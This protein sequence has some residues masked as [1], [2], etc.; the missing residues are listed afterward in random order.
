MQKRDTLSFILSEQRD[1]NVQ[2][3][4]DAYAKYLNEVKDIF[5]VSAYKLATSDWYFDPN[6]HKCPH[7][8]WL[9][10]ITISEPSEGKRHEIRKTSIKIE[11]IGAYQ[12]GCIEFYYPR[13]YSFLL[14]SVAVKSGHQDWRYDE[15]RLSN[16]GLL[17]HEIEWSGPSD[18]ARWRIEAND[19]IYNWIPFKTSHNKTT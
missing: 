17:V 15:F 14:D 7:D 11:L 8:A 3:A 6:H 9:E 13:V 18:T 1:S 4:F 10:K 16:S 2:S 12:D 5:P 19:V